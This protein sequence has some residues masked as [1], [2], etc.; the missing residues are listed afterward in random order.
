MTPNNIYKALCRAHSSTWANGHWTFPIIYFHWRSLG[1]ASILHMVRLQCIITEI[2]NGC[3][4]VKTFI[5]LEMKYTTNYFYT[6]KTMYYQLRYVWDKLCTDVRNRK[7]VLM[8][9]LAERSKHWWIV[10]CFGCIK[11][12]SCIWLPF[13]HFVQDPPQNV[14]SYSHNNSR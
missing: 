2:Q 9:T 3:H 4:S 6:T 13:S 5:R 14:M 8:K 12:V 1:H 10:R 11:V 7:W